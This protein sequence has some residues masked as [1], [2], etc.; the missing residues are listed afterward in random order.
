MSA[1]CAKA[2]SLKRHAMTLPTHEAST[3]PAWMAAQ[4]HGDV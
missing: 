3:K 2:R 4:V 1:V